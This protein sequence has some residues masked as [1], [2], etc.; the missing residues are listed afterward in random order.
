MQMT[1]SLHS[2]SR[3]VHSIF[4]SLVDFDWCALGFLKMGH[5]FVPW[6][7][8]TRRSG[9][10][11]TCLSL[12]SRLFLLLKKWWQCRNVTFNKDFRIHTSKQMPSP[13]VHQ[14]GQPRMFWHC[15]LWV[16]FGSS[17]EMTLE[18]HA[19]EPKSQHTSSRDSYGSSVCLGPGH[20]KIWSSGPPAS[21]PSVINFSVEPSLPPTPF[22]L[23]FFYFRS[24]SS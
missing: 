10:S 3:K 21:Y 17:L 16:V 7:A 13:P 22:S 2:F 18:G 4:I 14:L 15:P 6:Q 23:P 12:F 19:T 5:P 9:A 1:D 24:I 8:V 11:F 20:Q